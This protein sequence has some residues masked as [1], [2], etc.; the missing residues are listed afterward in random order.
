MS[1]KRR[2]TRRP[3]SDH[4]LVFWRDAEGRYWQERAA[5]TDISATGMAI[6]LR[7]R[8]EPRTQIGL[9]TRPDG[10]TVSASLRHIRQKGLTYVAGLEL[11]RPELPS[12]G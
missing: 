8:I 12:R 10:V 7:N 3:A 9:R 5:I 4:T 1:E 11:P 6:V 2:D